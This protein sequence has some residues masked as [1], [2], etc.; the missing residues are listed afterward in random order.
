MPR[1]Y[2]DLNGVKQASTQ[3]WQDAVL[4]PSQS[5]MQFGNP[6]EL[7]VVVFSSQRAGGGTSRGNF[8]LSL[9]CALVV[10][11]PGIGGPAHTVTHALI[12]SH[13]DYGNA[14]Y[15][16]WPLKNI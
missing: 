11:I 13:L 16:G 2:G 1:G 7:T 5:C 4:L 3:L 15:A 6:P 9:F 10:P 8:C 12:I 14:L